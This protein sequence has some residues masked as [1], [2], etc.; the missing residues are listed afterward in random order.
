M[1]KSKYGGLNTRIG[2]LSIWNAS[3]DA[4]I[5]SMQNFKNIKYFAT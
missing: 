1:L 4:T 5:Y 3:D 2:F